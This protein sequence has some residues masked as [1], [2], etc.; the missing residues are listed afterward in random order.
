M[1]FQ[2]SHVLAHANEKLVGT[3]F[4]EETIEEL[5][6]VPTD[7]FLHDKFFKEYC[8]T[9]NAQSAILPFMDTDVEVVVLFKKSHIYQGEPIITTNIY[10]INGS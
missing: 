9:L 6:I 8:S 4:Y 7:K 10:N 5:L 3:I 2:E 1:T